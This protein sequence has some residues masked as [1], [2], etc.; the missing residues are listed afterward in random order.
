[1][2]SAGSSVPLPSASAPLPPP[3]TEPPRSIN[4]DPNRRTR[5]SG[6][7]APPPT[8]ENGESSPRPISERQGRSITERRLATQ[9]PATNPAD[10]A[11]CIKCGML[12]HGDAV[13][14]SRCGQGMRDLS[15]DPN[16]ARSQ[17]A[18][19]Q[20][21]FHLGQ[22]KEAGALYARLAER[23]T[24]RRA[25]AILRSKERDAR[26]QEN[27]NQ[28]QEI[29]SRTKGLLQRGDIK[30]SIEVLERG[31]AN[32]RDAGASSTGAETKL[33]ADLT[34][35]RGRLR[36]RRNV[37]ILI[38]VLILSVLAIIVLY[39]LSPQGS[40]MLGLRESAIPAA[41]PAPTPASN[42]ASP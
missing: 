35:L 16:A 6:E 31:L 12:N 7:F 39:V 13:S 3:P 22:F 20:R 14:C 27:Q 1:M 5:V 36:Q 23:E 33:M 34:A 41:V 25:R 24:D 18:E 15:N 32:V 10:G 19:A 30:S 28:L 42:E 26:T 29:K 4:A 21:L 9:R 11:T 37:R 17:E 40:R 38:V 2:P 8:N